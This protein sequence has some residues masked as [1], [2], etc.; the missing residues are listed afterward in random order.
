ML[1][2][3]CWW[4]LASEEE[5][6]VGEPQLLSGEAG[7]ALLVAPWPVVTNACSR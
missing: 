1:V 7:D 3:Q 2:G 5:V 6:V 4:R